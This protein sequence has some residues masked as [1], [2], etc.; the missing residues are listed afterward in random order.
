LHIA[1][2]IQ[3]L[4]FF[5][6]LL[7]PTFNVT[8]RSSILVTISAFATGIV[9]QSNYTFPSGFNPGEI[10]PSQAA[11]WCLSERNTC[12]Q[13]CVDG[14]SANNC[15]AGSLTFSCTCANG[16][17][18]DLSKYQG[19]MPFFIC[20]ANFGQCQAN[21]AGDLDAQ[22][23]CT[24]QNI[25]GS[26]TADATTATTSSAAATTSSQATITSAPKTASA[27]TAAATS[28]TSNGAGVALQSAQD[29]STGLF[30]TLLMSTLGLFL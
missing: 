14:T 25:C 15:D 29:H 30:I 28:T 24:T 3:F 10:T 22:K 13:V 2:L 11:S 16:T 20:Q 12:P 4:V 7:F 8:M 9:A 6:T 18:P 23:A 1:L 27:T 5:L 19:S 17:V 21:N 26:L